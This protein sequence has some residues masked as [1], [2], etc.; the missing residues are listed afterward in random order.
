MSKLLKGKILLGF[1]P[2]VKDFPWINWHPEFIGWM[3][4]SPGY[5]SQP[6]SVSLIVE[7]IESRRILDMTPAE[8]LYAEFFRHE[9]TTVVKDMDDLVLLA[10]IEKLSHIA[11]EAKARVHAAKHERDERVKKKAGSRLAKLK[12][13]DDEISTSDAI[14]NIKARGEKISKQEKLIA[15]L[16]KLPGIDRKQAEQMLSAGKIKDQSLKT[17]DEKVAEKESLKEVETRVNPFASKVSSTPEEPTNTPS[18]EIISNPV[19]S[20]NPFAKKI[21]Q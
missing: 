8:E 9:S 17:E 13:S 21:S 12:A 15:Q 10:H 20:S 4:N 19:P 18:P 14:N 1:E 6:C 16:M 7:I 11:L 2:E 3:F 5:V